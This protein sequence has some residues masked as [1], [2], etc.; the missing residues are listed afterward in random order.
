MEPDE[1]G[2]ELKICDEHP[3][4]CNWIVQGPDADGRGILQQKKSVPFARHQIPLEAEE[5]VRRFFWGRRC[6]GWPRGRL[7]LRGL[8]EYEALMEL[9]EALLNM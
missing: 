8:R 1:D 4:Y 7:L 2:H 5:R 9:F 3:G 6:R